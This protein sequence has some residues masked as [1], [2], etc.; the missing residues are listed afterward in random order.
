MK[1][2]EEAAGLLLL[3]AIGV[4]LAW[5]ATYELTESPL[6]YRSWS[7]R[8]CVRVEPTSSGDCDDLPERYETIWVK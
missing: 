7:T 6:V 3:T 2:L 4:G 1:F 5:L 8:E